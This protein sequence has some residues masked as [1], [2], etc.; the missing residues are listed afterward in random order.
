MSTTPVGHITPPGSM[1]IIKSSNKLDFYTD[2]IE[3][4]KTLEPGKVYTFNVDPHFL[5]MWLSPAEP[6]TIPEKIYDFEQP[7]R[8]QV[9][10][11]LNTIS[12]NNNIGVLL[13]GYKGQ[14]K[15]VIAK[16][17]AI[18]S[19]LPVITI[20][21][22]IPKAADFIKFLSGI[23]QDY[24]LFI[25]EFEKLFL[26]MVPQSENDNKLHTQDSFLSFLDGTSGLN[27]KRLVIFTSN[28]EIGDKFINR[29]SRIRYYKKFNF[30]R[31]EVFDAIVADKLINKTH[32]ED[33]ENNLDIPSTTIDLLTSIIDEINIHDIPF[34]E[35]KPFFNQKDREIIYTRYKRDED[36]KFSFF[37]DVKTNREIG[38]EN[39][40]AKNVFGYHINVIS[41]DGETIFYEEED[42]EYDD[43]DN[44][45]S[46]KKVLYKAVKQKWEKKFD[47]VA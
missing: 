35:F 15:S 28:K 42:V 27:N 5:N 20:N 43:N 22:Q 6:F 24:V 11:T 10:R 40:Y 34:S 21:S 13:E 16:Q 14:G 46:K 44:V 23:K 9:L 47:L 1:T 26:E 3:V 32:K 19:G 41:N 4:H 2:V 17:L 39:E 7:F 38:V 36:G 31:K 45:K 37:D 33:L 12:A 8:A 30:M 29:P 25:D 18:E